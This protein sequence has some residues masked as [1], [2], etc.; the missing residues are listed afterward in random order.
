MNFYFQSVLC[1][2]P[3]PYPVLQTSA[4]NLFFDTPHS[5]QI[6]HD[7]VSALLYHTS[8]SQQIIHDMPSP[9]NTDSENKIHN[10]LLRSLSVSVLLL[11]RYILS[12]RDSTRM[13]VKFVFDGLNHASLR[14]ACSESDVMSLIS[15][16]IESNK[17]SK[18]KL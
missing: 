1:L 9:T 2:K 12:Q 11:Y 14:S 5:L 13:S 3:L 10:N 15:S 18:Y 6:L 7:F 4:R 17:V 8:H 16:S